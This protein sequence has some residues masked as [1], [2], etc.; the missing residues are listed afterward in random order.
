MYQ[1]VQPIC[2]YKSTPHFCLPIHM[3]HKC[4]PI[5]S[6]NSYISICTFPPTTLLCTNAP[7]SYL[8]TNPPTPLYVVATVLRNSHLL[9]CNFPS[10]G[11]QT[12]LQRPH[13]PC[14]DFMSSTYSSQDRQ[15]TSKHTKCTPSRSVCIPATPS[16][17]LWACDMLACEC[18]CGREKTKRV[19]S[20]VDVAILSCPVMRLGRLDK[21]LMESNGL[22]KKGS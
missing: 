16:N 13:L 19:S 10:L 12:V 8:C 14:K 21:K 20:S 11:T 2:T 22:L 6:T 9:L 15:D 4:V 17:T 5:H 3:I 1:S 7:K 18:P